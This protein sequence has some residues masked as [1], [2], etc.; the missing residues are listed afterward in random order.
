MK[1]I[2]SFT[3]D[4]ETIEI[5]EKIAKELKSNRSAALRYVVSQFAKKT[6]NSGSVVLDCPHT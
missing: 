2:Y 3:L 4:K 1:E 6:D 5:L